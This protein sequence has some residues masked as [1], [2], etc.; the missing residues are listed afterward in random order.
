MRLGAQ[1]LIPNSKLLIRMMPSAAQLVI[2]SEIEVWLLF[3]KML[4]FAA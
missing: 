1:F 4:N 3:G 2:N